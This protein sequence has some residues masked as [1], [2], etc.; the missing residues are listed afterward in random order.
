V[1]VTLTASRRASYPP[2]VDI[3]SLQGRRALVC[4]S[5]QGIGR[6]AAL[7]LAS[8]GAVVTLFARDATALERAREELPGTGHTFLVADF[9]DNDSVRT[10]TTSEIRD[11]GAF[12]VL[13]NNT[14]GP[15]AGPIVD[16]SPEAFVAAFRAHLVN[17][18]ILAQAVI[19]GMKD[20]GYGRI[21]NIVSTSV[22]EPI[23]G[24]GVSNTVRAAVA[25]WA[26]TIAG[27]V[28][29][30]GITVNNVLPGFTKTSRLDAIIEGRAQAAGRT[31]DEITRDMLKQVPAGR[32]A[33]SWEIAA[34]IGFL[35]SPAGG[36]VTGVS[37]PVD[38]GR[39]SSL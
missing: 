17:N 37:L 34:A 36:Y 33:E 25:G 35:A 30:F 11:R 23:A 7:E 1:R 16:A 20:A 32:F 9:H 29:R 27:E 22:R 12:H 13:V 18:Q 8:R 14:G 26:K 19:P 5:T 24:L 3:H 28:A 38:G 4:G 15:P 39:I 10:A 21:V 31:T 6:A 2:P